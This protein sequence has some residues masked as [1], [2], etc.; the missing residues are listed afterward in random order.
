MD[1]VSGKLSVLTEHSE[2]NLTEY[3]R[4]IQSLRQQHAL[5]QG[6]FIYY[7][8]LRSYTG[9]VNPD[10]SF[11]ANNKITTNYVICVEIE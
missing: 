5:L 9:F 11:V 3:Q 10:V 6:E 2:E 1:N 4:T 7:A 8:D